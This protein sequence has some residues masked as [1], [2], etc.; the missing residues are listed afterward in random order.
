MRLRRITRRFTASITIVALL[1]TQAAVAGYACPSFLPMTGME[2]VTDARCANGSDAERP[3]L[4]KAH[5]ETKSQI[6]DNYAPPQP[7]PP[8]AILA[9]LPLPLDAA[10]ATASNRSDTY[11]LTRLAADSSPPLFLR[12]Q[13]LRN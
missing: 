3:G 6:G 2:S 4:C 1:F 10:A 8:V 7:P 12:F 5:S 13:V 11:H 9:F